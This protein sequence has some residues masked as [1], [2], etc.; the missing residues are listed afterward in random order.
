MPKKTRQGDL[1]YRDVIVFK[2]GGR[3][4]MINALTSEPNGLGSSPGRGLCV[5]FLGKT[6]YFHSASRE[7]SVGGNPAMD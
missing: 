3:G 6:L 2:C 7:F 4:L 1:D 5:V